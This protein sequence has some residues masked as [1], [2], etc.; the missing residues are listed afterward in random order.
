MIKM[1]IK[2]YNTNL[3]LEKGAEVAE[4][5]CGACV[6]IYN[7][8]KYSPITLKEVLKD[9]E[10]CMSNEVFTEEVNKDE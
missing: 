10:R 4:L 5:L 8:M 7:I 6:L 2:D 3:Q 1:E 9:I